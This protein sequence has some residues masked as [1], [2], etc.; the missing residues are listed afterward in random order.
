VEWREREKRENLVLAKQLLMTDNGD[1]FTF[2][3]I[4]HIRVSAKADQLS[5]N[6]HHFLD[7]LWCSCTTTPTTTCLQRVCEVQRDRDRKRGG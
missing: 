5:Q 4:V 7:V 6:V 1:A 3:W 2:K